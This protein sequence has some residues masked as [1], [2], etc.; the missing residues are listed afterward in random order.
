MSAVILLSLFYVRLATASPIEDALNWNI[1]QI[2]VLGALPITPE[3]IAEIGYKEVVYD[4]DEKI[5]K[6]FDARK[7]WPKCTSLKTVWDQGGC[8]ACWAVGSASVMG[9]RYCIRNQGNVVLSAYDIMSCCKNC[10]SK[11][12]CKGGLAIRAWQHWNKVG[13]VTGGPTK[14]SGCTCYQYEGVQF[15]CDHKCRAGYRKSYDSDLTYGR[16]PKILRKNVEK[17][18]REIMTNGPVVAI[19][20]VFTDFVNL[21]K[22]V[23]IH[24]SGG[25]FSHHVVR[26]IGWGEKKVSGKPVPYWLAVNSRGKQWG[27]KGLFRILRG[28]NHCGFESTIMAD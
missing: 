19:F 4:E 13:V 23:Y 15:N 12:P 16:P 6:T 21:G 8:G 27:D 11:G 17:I 26:V 7:K 20:Q 5:P 28:E 14:C 3:M 25:L 2:G 18:Q 22:E 24:K 9:D 1:S 10:T